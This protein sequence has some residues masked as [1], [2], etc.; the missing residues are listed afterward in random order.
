MR[1]ERVKFDSSVKQAEVSL[2][3]AMIRLLEKLGASDFRRPGDQ[4]RA[5]LRACEFR[6]E[7]SASI[8]LE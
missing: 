2:R 6:S 3:Q 4:R 5:E 1:L 8:C 7:F